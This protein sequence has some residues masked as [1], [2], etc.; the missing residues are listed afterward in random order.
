MQNKT[1]FI[2]GATQKL[3]LWGGRFETLEQRVARSTGAGR[4]SIERELRRLARKKRS[5]ERHLQEAAH[6]TTNVEWEDVRGQ[7]EEALED[8]DSLASKVRVSAE[9]V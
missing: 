8:F 5:L 4:E 2:A 3:D 9:E 6:G 7:L 1:D